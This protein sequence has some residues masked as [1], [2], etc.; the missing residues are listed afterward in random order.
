MLAS[1]ILGRIAYLVYNEKL[2]V[3]L[4]ENALYG[5]R[6]TGETVEAGYKDVFHPTV[7]KLCQDARPK[8]RTLTVGNIHAKQIFVLIIV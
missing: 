5:I 4:R 2:H 3:C 1:Y 6:E 8:V 7:L